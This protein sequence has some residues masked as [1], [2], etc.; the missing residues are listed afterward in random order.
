MAVRQA[1]P[2]R[3][4]TDYHGQYLGQDLPGHKPEPFAPGIFSAWNDYGLHPQSTVVIAPGGGQIYFTDESYPVVKGRSQSIWMMQQIN[5]AWTEPHIASF[6]SDY[7]DWGTFLSEDGRVIYFVSTRPPGGKG[8]ADDADI[9]YVEENENGFSAPKRLGHPV[10]TA[11]GEV[12]GTVASNG[13]LLFTSNRPGGKGGFDIYLTRSINGDYSEPVGLGEGV[14][15]GADERVMCVSPDLSFLMLHRYDK[16][17]EADAGL[18]V[19]YR[20]EDNSWTRAKSIGDHINMLNVTWA[21]LSPDGEHLFILGLGYGIY[22]LRTELIDYLRRVDL[23]ISER[24][25]RGLCDQGIDSACAEYF[26]MK[27]RHAKYVELDEFFLNQRGYQLL[28][29]GDI[30]RSIGLFRICVEI[31]PA[32]WNAHDSLA[33]AYLAA[34]ETDHAKIHY[35]RSLEL[36]P[37]NGNAR[38]RLNELE[39]N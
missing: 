34:G 21:S 1:S 26:E 3:E 37:E 20:L 6:S 4:M 27:N 28:Q 23:N 29:A 18:Y 5:G 39:M 11:F 19:S 12:S 8:P 36:N 32:S 10:N 17:N 22:W 30:T 14:N 33:E 38:R 16:N 31:F 24:L 7:S 25:Y 9:W 2:I 13:V 35:R 15:T